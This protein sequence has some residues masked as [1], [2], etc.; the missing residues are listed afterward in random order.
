M[1]LWRNVKSSLHIS[2]A[3]HGNLRISTRLWKLCVTFGVIHSLFGFILTYKNKHSPLNERFSIVCVCGRC[4]KTPCRVV[5]FVKKLIWSVT[6]EMPYSTVLVRLT[7]QMSDNLRKYSDCHISR[8]I[9][10]IEQPRKPSFVG[11]F[12]RQRQRCL[13]FCGRFCT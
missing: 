3:N 2:F 12:D 7:M 10:N 11:K 8:E 9:L 13:L 4:N 5:Q 6:N 1:L